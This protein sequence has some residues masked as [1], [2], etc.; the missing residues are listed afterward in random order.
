MNLSRCPY[1]CAVKNPYSNSGSTSHAALT[2]E[3]LGVL[4]WTDSTE[5]VA[6]INKSLSTFNETLAQ[7]AIDLYNGTTIGK[8][9]IK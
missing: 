3:T 7:A 1:I 6:H 4:N 8:E 9:V 2:S 5:F